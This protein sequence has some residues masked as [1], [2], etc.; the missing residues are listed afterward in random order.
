MWESRRSYTVM[1]KH[2]LTNWLMFPND[3]TWGTLALL[4]STPVT[5]Q[6]TTADKIL[7][8]VI[9][10]MINMHKEH[11][12][13]LNVRLHLTDSDFSSASGLKGRVESFSCRQTDSGAGL[14]LSRGVR[15]TVWR[16]WSG[17]LLPQSHKYFTVLYFDSYTYTILLPQ[18][19]N[20]WIKRV[21]AIKK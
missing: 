2:L 15:V 17:P 5:Q 4:I 1:V 12:W 9:G 13:G 21:Y 11:G 3:T 20:M 6:I 16:C 8:V 19:L 14:L 10:V 18:I 7:H